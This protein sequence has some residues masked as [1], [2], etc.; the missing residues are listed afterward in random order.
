MDWRQFCYLVIAGA[1]LLL[2]LVC[3]IIIS[4][5]EDNSI[6]D[7]IAGKPIS[8]LK[9]DAWYL[10]AVG[11]ISLTACFLLVRKVGR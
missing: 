11:T 2:V 1:A 10:L 7:A 8:E 9:L 3:F 4:A 6:L 5:P